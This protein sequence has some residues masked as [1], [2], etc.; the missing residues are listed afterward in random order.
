MTNKMGM[1]DR[2]V[3]ELRILNLEFSRPEDEVVGEHLCLL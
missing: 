1:I 2:I 3:L